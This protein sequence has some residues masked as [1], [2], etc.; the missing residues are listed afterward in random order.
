MENTRLALNPAQYELLNTL[1]VVHDEEDMKDLKQT[2]VK[3][4]DR[5]LQRE[6][7][8]LMANGTLTE[9]KIAGWETEHM[10]TPYK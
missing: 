6:F 5:V 7:D 2:L 10:R 8:R 3:F 4:L 1:S 9:E